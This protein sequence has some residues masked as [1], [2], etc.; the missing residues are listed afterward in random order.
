MRDDTA[1]FLFKYLWTAK[2]GSTMTMP[3]SDHDDTAMFTNPK[4]I[5]PQGWTSPEG[6]HFRNPLR[7][8]FRGSQ[9]TL[10]GRWIPHTLHAPCNFRIAHRHTHVST[11][12]ASIAALVASMHIV[13]CLCLW[14]VRRYESLITNEYLED[15]YA[16]PAMMP[17]TPLERAH[18]RLVINRS[19]QASLA[20]KCATN[21]V[22]SCV[23]TDCMR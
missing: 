14:L 21:H 15:A 1:I 7:I 11:E 5:T 2:P 23:L 22:S 4:H 20:L 12:S 19:V 16:Q 18:A 6:P 17:R 9:F 13:D 3:G 8:M 10:D